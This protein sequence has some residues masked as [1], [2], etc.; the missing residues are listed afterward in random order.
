MAKAKV[1]RPN[2]PKKPR[3]KAKGA[4]PWHF[5]EKLLHQVQTPDGRDFVPPDVMERA[6]ADYRERIKR[7]GPQPI[8][9]DFRPA[10]EET[11]QGWVS[12]IRM[13]G[14]D[15]FVSGRLDDSPAGE[16]AQMTPRLVF[17]YRAVGVPEIDDRSGRFVYS[18]IRIIVIS[19][20]DEAQFV[21]GTECLM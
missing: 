13:R 3:K 20:L 11:I 5:R 15:V 12:R 10:N 19:A 17:G 9:E 14:P 21:R 6:V 18:S 4:M 8:T 16:R 1:K 7:D 2:N